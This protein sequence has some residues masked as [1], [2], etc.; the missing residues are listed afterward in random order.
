MAFPV[1]VFVLHVKQGY[2]ARAVHM[3]KMLG[4][5]GIDFEYI[6][7]WDIP[8]IDDETL[9]RH[10]TGQMRQKP[11]AASCGLKHLDV[12]RRMLRDDIPYALVLEDD[13]LL[14]KNFRKVFLAS[15]KELERSHGA[16]KPFWLGMEATCMGFTP[17]SI[18]KKGQYVYPGRFLQCAGCYLINKS[19]AKVVLDEISS[20]K[21]DLPIDHY[22]DSL[23]ARGLFD[24]YWTHPVIAEQGSH[25]GLMP[26]AIGNPVQGPFKF[27]R[28]SLTFFYKKILYF[29]R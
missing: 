6:L 4:K 29:F 17:R 26:S 15:L 22:I 14:K 24:S 1:K 23:R 9:S 8:D 19:L 11:A 7:D 20:A 3:E 16:E 13:M 28:R 25:M 10:F 5:M 12:Y 18:R 27:A 2:E 21:T